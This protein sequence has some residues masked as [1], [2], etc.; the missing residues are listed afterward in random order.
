MSIAILLGAITGATERYAENID[1]TEKQELKLQIKRQNGIAQEKVQLQ[2]KDNLLALPVSEQIRF[3]L[4]PVGSEKTIYDSGK[5]FVLPN[6][7]SRGAN[8]QQSMA[9]LFGLKLPN[10]KSFVSSLDPYGPLY[11]KTKNTLA[12]EFSTLMK[13]FRDKGEMG[14]DE[15]YQPIAEA[16]GYWDYKDPRDRL[17]IRDALTQAS[18][19]DSFSAEFFDYVPEDPKVS[20]LM[21]DI[22]T[23]NLTKGDIELLGN[24]GVDVIQFSENEDTQTLSGSTYGFHYINRQGV[25]ITPV[26]INP[27]HNQI[28]LDVSN[29]Y[30]GDPSRN[31]QRYASIFK[32]SQQIKE[33]F[34]VPEQVY[35]NTL[36]NLQR[37]KNNEVIRVSGTGVIYGGEQLALAMAPVYYGTESFGA[38]IDVFRLGFM[39][40]DDV[41]YDQLQKKGQGPNAIDTTINNSVPIFLKNIGYE[42]RIE[43][44]KSYNAAGEL[45]TTSRDL[46]ALVTNPVKEGDPASGPAVLGPLGVLDQAIL[47]FQTFGD[48]LSQIL[49]TTS[50][51]YGENITDRNHYLYGVDEEITALTKKISQTPNDTERQRAII[52]ASRAQLA[53]LLR[54]KLAY[55]FAK[56]LESSTGNSRLSDTDVRISGIAQGLEGLLANSKTAPTVLRYMMRSAKKE[57]DYKGKLL[58]GSMEE[59]QAAEALKIAFS[60]ES[61]LRIGDNILNSDNLTKEQIAAMYQESVIRA[62]NKMA[63]HDPDFQK[64]E[65]FDAGAEEILTV[66]GTL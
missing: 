10:G 12:G 18:N 42:N 33:D 16:I 39:S 9:N 11:Q 22:K 53:G 46:L 60:G 1:T 59:M 64:Q 23:G 8:P 65:G 6:V 31:T 30:S 5:N 66:E 29:K 43:L 62:I 56:S 19:Q 44:Q 50:P 51:N 45:Y 47:R 55:T 37:L 54:K 20:K 57:M 7:V 34:R 58:T 63:D 13:E 35:A 32:A 28:M 2:S 17:M 49:G 27:E 61:M 36:S 26:S 14:K 15:N 4:L 48:E 3:G 52:R 25:K 41:Y 38:A 24:A 40:L 21:S